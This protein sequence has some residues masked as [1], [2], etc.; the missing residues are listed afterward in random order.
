M[1]KQDQSFVS[2]AQLA[3]PTPST[4]KPAPLPSGW[5]HL[6]QWDQIK[7]SNQRPDTKLR[8][9]KHRIP[10]L[11]LK[12]H[13]SHS[14]LQSTII[15]PKIY[16]IRTLQGSHSVCLGPRTL[17]LWEYIADRFAQRVAS[18]GIASQTSDT[19]DHSMLPKASSSTQLQKVSEFGHLTTMFCFS[20]KHQDFISHSGTIPT[21]YTVL[22]IFTMT[23]IV[24]GK[25]LQSWV[26][27]WTLAGV[28]PETDCWLGH[29]A[30]TD[31]QSRKD[32]RYKPSRG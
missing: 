17:S 26:L 13:W 2:K 10:W 31:E 8:S 32:A 29:G 24:K 12:E 16:S 7:T 19:D 4:K 3:T 23:F 15:R 28:C 20:Q 27:R 9:S 6:P 22:I 14:R 25:W 21:L 5:S 18:N 30:Q 11:Y 1:E